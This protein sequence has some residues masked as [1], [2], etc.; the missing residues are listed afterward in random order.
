MLGLLVVEVGGLDVGV[1]QLIVASKDGGM[2]H[3]I[4]YDPS[5]YSVFNPFKPLKPYQC[6]HA[7]AVVKCGFY[8]CG[9]SRSDGMKVAD[10]AAEDEVG[11]VGVEVFYGADM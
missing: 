11:F 5:F 6:H 10:A 2:T 8:A 7:S 4:V 9:A 1:C 3:D